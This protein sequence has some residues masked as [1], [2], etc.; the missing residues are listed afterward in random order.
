MYT[1]QSKRAV[2]CTSYCN[3]NTQ[4]PGLYRSVLQRWGSRR[5]VCTDHTEQTWECLETQWRRTFR[6]RLV[7]A[8]RMMNSLSHILS[9]LLK[10]E[11]RRYLVTL[12]TSKR[13]KAFASLEYQML[14]CSI[15]MDYPAW[16]CSSHH[17]RNNYSVASCEN[18]SDVHFLEGMNYSVQIWIYSNAS[19]FIY[20]YSIVKLFQRETNR[21][22]FAVQEPGLP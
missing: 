3:C 7:A 5:E 9:E 18:S 16:D 21:C 6:T 17:K 15:K 12:C 10:T 13:K 20:H 22:C 11:N 2:T 1:L 8:L 14:N 19:S 4:S